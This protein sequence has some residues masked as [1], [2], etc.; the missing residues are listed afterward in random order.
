MRQLGSILGVSW[1]TIG[2]HGLILGLS[3]GHLGSV[4]GFS[5]GAEPPKTVIVLRFFK[6]FVVGP[7]FLQLRLLSTLLRQPGPSWVH[8]GTI[9]GHLVAVLG[10]L[11]AILGPS[12][13]ILGPS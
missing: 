6:V 2:S 8:L 5:G 4:L 12:W 9:L 13:A 3:W 7:L 1:L 11:G 10:K